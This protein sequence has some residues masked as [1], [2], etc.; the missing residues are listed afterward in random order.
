M[1]YSFVKCNNKIYQNKKNQPR[2]STGLIS[3]K[4]PVLKI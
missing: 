4:F 3:K 1:R 2:F